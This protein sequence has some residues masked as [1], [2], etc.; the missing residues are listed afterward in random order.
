[1]AE[2]EKKAEKEA[3]APE[4]PASETDLLD[5]IVEA[6]RIKPGDSGY[7]ATKAGLEAFLAELIQTDPDA[8]ISSQLVDDM[9][10]E[11]DK[12]LT[13]QMDLIL[14]DETFRKLES[15][16][17]SLKYLVDQTDFRQN[18]RVEFINLSKEDLLNDFQDS[19]EI[20]K[21]GLYKH[22][23]TAEY[24]QFGGKPFSSI[25]SDYDFGPGPRDMELLRYAAQVAA[26][27]HAP[28]IGAASESFF[29]IKSWQ[30][31]PNL[32]DIHSILEGPQY[33][34]W[35]SF[36]ENEDARYVGLTMPKFLLRLP[37]G[38]DTV[39]VK[40]FN[41]REKA[42]NLDE[43]SWGNTS[44]AFASRLADSFAK[45]RWNTNV[46]GPQGGGAVENLPLYHFEEKGS[47]QTRIPTQTM[48]SERREFE[49]AEEGFM[50]LTM[51]KDSDNAAFFSANSALA[52]KIFPNTPEGK[53]AETNYKLSC[54]LPYMYVMNRLAHY[55]KVMQRENIGTWKSRTDLEREL[56]KWISRYVTE[57]DNPDPTT[58]SKRPLRAAEIIV[59]DVEGDPGWYAVSIKATPHFK[60]MGA[61]FTLSLTGKLDKT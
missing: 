45:Y 24:G 19:P 33:A 32:K 15:S 40:S 55:V 57:M 43:F 7:D 16:W 50:A 4:A 6:S 34:A 10:L 29:G 12:K 41:Y 25:I 37:Y 48:I 20:V 38:Q 56:N 8:K 28:F 36:R 9:I 61:N 23:Y 58:R 35:R 26:M 3:A 39:P 22:V 5:R 2:E 11:L 1:M 18:N 44:F 27:S 47:L 54:Q 49:L 13:K 14:H 52:P 17:R 59:S 53:I 31:L 46:I 21:S 60:Y 51:R 30:E 42:D